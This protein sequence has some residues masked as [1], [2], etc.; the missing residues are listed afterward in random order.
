MMLFKYLYINECDIFVNLNFFFEN[1]RK[2]MVSVS[3]FVMH[4]TL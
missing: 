2:V 3:I 4:L 1:D